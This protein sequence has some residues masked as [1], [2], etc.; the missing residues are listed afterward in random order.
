MLIHFSMNSTVS[1]KPVLNLHFNFYNCNNNSLEFVNLNFNQVLTSRQ[2]TFKILKSN[3][4]RIGLNSL[5]NRLHHIN[6]KI[7]LEWLNL[8]IEMYQ[9]KCKKLLF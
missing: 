6:D 3:R 9:V 4:M 1:S 8:S 7:P 2:T 5:A